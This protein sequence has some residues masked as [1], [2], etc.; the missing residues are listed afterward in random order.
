MCVGRGYLRLC[1]SNC[2]EAALVIECP[3][4]QGENR[5]PRGS[6]ADYIVSGTYDSQITEYERPTT[7]KSI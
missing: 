3:T 4:A 2:R 1:L 7:M 6:L 5:V